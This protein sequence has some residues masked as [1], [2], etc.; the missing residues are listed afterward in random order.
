[1]VPVP[2]TEAGVLI[3]LLLTIAAKTHHPPYQSWA[4]HQ[5][6]WSVTGAASSE[7]AG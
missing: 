2:C 5:P 4:V 1:M 3:S 7:T 6:D